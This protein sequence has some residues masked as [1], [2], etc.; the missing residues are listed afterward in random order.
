[1]ELSLFSVS[2][3][4]YWG[5]DS[6]DAVGFVE[7]AA[8][9]GYST[10][11]LAGKRPHGSPLDMDDESI[12]HLREVLERTGVR[13]GVMAGYTDFGGQVAAEVPFLEMQIRYVQE[14]CR[15]GQQLGAPVCR[16]FTAYEVDGVSPHATWA[17]SVRCLQECCDRAADYG[18]TIAIQN[19]HDIAVDS[20]ALLEFLHDVDRP[21]CRLGADAWSPALRGEELYEAAR[22]LAPH[23]AITTSADYVRLPRFRY[24]PELIS[25]E[26]APADLV[27]AVPFGTGFIDYEAFFRGLREG[28]FDGIATFE[29]CSPVRGGGAIENLDRFAETYVEWMREHG[30]D[31]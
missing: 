28:G 12:G 26:S 8:Q 2:Y 27:R 29:M 20:D 30:F 17:Q 19:H 11:M 21:N 15:I 25:Y 13:C 18:I 16:V 6:L 5:Q 31:A 4:G 22:K 9:L 14:L 23:A 7:K 1:M 3:A 10:I 24:R